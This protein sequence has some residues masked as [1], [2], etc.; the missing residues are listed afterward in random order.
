LA[1]EVRDEEGSGSMTNWVRVATALRYI[2]RIPEVFR[3]RAL[4]EDWWA[5]TSGY[6]GLSGFPLP[7]E[8]R[9]RDGVQY[10]LEELGDLETFWEVY[11]HSAYRVRPTDRVIVDAGA[12]IGLFCCFAA[13][14]V[15]DGVIFAL[16]P[17][18]DTYE[19]L[20]EHVRRNY[21]TSRI[22]TFNVALGSSGGTVSMVSSGRPS[23]SFHVVQSGE[24]P[25]ATPVRV[26]AVRLADF[27]ER[28]PSKA[29]DLLKMDIE[30]SEYD[31]LLSCTAADLARIR[32]IDLEY[33]TPPSAPGLS[34]ERLL[35]HLASC[36][37]GQIDRVGTA[38]YGKLYMTRTS[39]RPHVQPGIAAETAALVRRQW[40]E[41][42]A[43]VRRARTAAR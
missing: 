38:D 11:F 21:L 42:S 19:R 35:D 10:R 25:R 28:I 27:L 6:V 4:A 3:C 15:P 32:R 17:I 18:P 23:Q 20:R 43:R 22:H 8:V 1:P 37:F 33:H 12:N 14:R 26:Q 9:L 16:E 34:R 5:L 39:I 30:G 2:Q 24:K 36:G 41:N 40:G 7:A 13:S 29:I 31:V